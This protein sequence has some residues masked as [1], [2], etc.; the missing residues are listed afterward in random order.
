MLERPAECS[1]CLARPKK[2]RQRA[3]QSGKKRHKLGEVESESAYNTK[4]AKADKV[5]QKDDSE[6][7]MYHFSVETLC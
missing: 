6:V 2:Q 5:K 4:E 1:Q 7:T 3:R